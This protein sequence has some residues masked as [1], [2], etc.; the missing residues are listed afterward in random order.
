MTILGHPASIHFVL[1]ISE[2]SHVFNHFIFNCFLEHF[3]GP[4]PKRFIES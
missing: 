1:Q 2:L 3:P 4:I